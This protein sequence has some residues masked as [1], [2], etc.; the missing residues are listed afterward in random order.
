M[1]RALLMNGLGFRFQARGNSMYPT[2]RDGEIL[3]VQPTS[4]RELRPGDI[5][6]FNDGQHF[7]AHRLVRVDEDMFVTR[8]D[9]ALDADDAIH[10]SQ[11]IGKVIAKENSSGAR[12]RL[13]SLC[14]VAAKLR[15]H[16]TRTRGTV[17]RR[18]QR[19]RLRQPM[20]SLRRV[21]SRPSCAFR[22]AC[23]L[24]FVMLLAAFTVHAQVAVDASTST[25]ARVTGTPTVN[26][27]HNT[28]GAN[29][30][31]IVGVSLNLTNSATA[32]VT[33]I[34]YN[35][36]ALTR[37]GAH[38]DAG[39]TRRVEMWSLLAPVTGN[40][41]VA[42][43]LSIPGGG[44]IGMVAGA[45]TFT[46]VDQTSP[47]APF[48]SADGA[49]GTFSSLDVP[50]MVNGFVIDTL[51]IG[52][53]LTVA[54]GASQTS[55]WNKSS[56]VNGVTDVR[57]T[58]STRPGAPSVPISETFGGTSNWSLGALALRPFQS[59]LAVTATGSSAFF[60]QNLTYT[61]KITNNG[62]STATGATLTDTLAAGLTLVSATPS[63]G[64]CAGTPTITCNLGTIAPAAMATVTIVVTPGAT[65]GY[66][67]T[68]TITSTTPD[69]VGGNNSATSVAFS[70]SNACSTP[71]QN[72]AGGTLAGIVNTYYPAT[73]NAAAGSKTITLGIATGSTTPIAIGD[74]LLVMQI[75]DAAINSTNTI[76][77]GD[78]FTGSGFTNPNSSGLY[79]FVTA[80][81]AVPLTGGTL[82]LTATGPGGGLIYS[83]T[84][85]A[86]TGAQGQRK[87]QVVR[88]PQ[89]STATLGSTLTAAAWN[90]STGGILALDVAG[91][92]TLGSATVSVNG[93]GFRGGAGMQLNGGTGTNTDFR[94]TAPAAY[95]GV[96]TP[97]ADGPK[98]EGIGGTPHWVESGVTFLNTGAEG[99]PNGSMARG[100]PGNAG[101]GGTDGDPNTASPNGNDQNAGGGGGAN[102]GAGGSGGDSWNS[103]LSS[104]GLAGAAFP[105][106]ITR[107]VLGGGGG[108]GSRNNSD[109]DLQAASGAAGGGIVI[110]RAGSLSGTATITAN[111]TAAYNGTAN[112]AAGAGGAGGSII[113]TSAQGGES[114]LTLSAHGGR[115]GDA[116]NTMAFSLGERHGPGGGGGGGVALISGP[117]ASIDVSGGGSGLTL[118][119]G[120]PYGA[121][122]GAAGTS[123]TNVPPLSLPGDQ[124][125]G[126]CVSDL[127]IAKS[128]TGNFTRGTSGTYTVTVSNI[129]LNMLTSGLVTVSDTLPIGLTPTAASGTGWSCS[130]SAQTLTCT[131]SDALAAGG[132]YPAISITVSVAQSAPNQVTNTAT[133]SGG[134][135]VNTNNDSAS[136]VTN[137]VSSAD[138]AITKAGSPNPVMQGQTLTYTLTVTNNGPSD[139]TGVSVSDTLPTQVSFVSATPS[140][141]TCSQASGTVTCALGTL[142][143][144]SSATITI[145][146]TAVT[147]SS[148]TN[149]ATVS[150]NEADP[151]SAN[152]T[153]SQ[154]EIITFP[155]RVSLV[156][157]TAQAGNGQTLLSWKTGSE[158]RNLGFNVYGDENGQ[159]V[160]LNPSLIAGSALTFRASLQQHTA[161]SYGWIDR[162]PSASGTYWLEDVDLDG[163]RTLHGPVSAQAAAAA[164]ANL[165]ASPTIAEVNKVPAVQ[166]SSEMSH[167]VEAVL[168]D[169]GDRKEL[170]EVQ[171][172]LAASPAVKIQVDHEGWYRVTQ[173][174]LVAAGLKASADA[175]YLQLYSQAIEQPIRITGATDGSGGFGPDA[176][177]EF[178]GTGVDTAY[179]SD[180]VYWLVV[181]NQPGKRIQDAS[182]SGDG[183]HQPQSFSYTVGL[184]QRT[185]YFAALLKPGDNFFGALVSTTPVDQ[186]LTLADIATAT[187]QNATVQIV[188]Q[189]VTDGTHDVNVS[190]NGSNL[191]DLTFGNQDEG[192]QSW[193]VPVNQL[194]A[195]PNTITL[196]AQNGA[197]DV[198]LVNYIRIRYQH[199]YTAE[200]DSLKFTAQAGDH[201]VVNGFQ[202]TPT[203]LVD[204]TDPYQPV[205]L[206][207]Q[208]ESVQGGYV[209]DAK[210]PWS[211]PGSHTLL[212][213]ADVQL[214][215]PAAMLANKPSHWHAAQAGADAVMI[216]YADFIGQ[217][218]PL[219]QL[220]KNQGKSV[221]V[222]DVEDL[223][224]E[225]AFGE[226]N[227][228]ALKEFLRAALAQWQKKPH[229]L[230]LVGDAS[231][232]PHNYLGFGFFDFVPTQIIP[233]SLLKTASDDW[234]SDFNDTGTAQIPTGRL[235]V[236]TQ[237]DATTV[238][239]KIV[240]YEKQQGGAWAE[241][242]LVVADVDDP[243]LSFTL[244]AE[245]VQALLPPSMMATDVFATNLD[246]NT[247]R[248]QILDGINS[249]KLLVNYNGHGSIEIWSGEDL[250]DNT[251]AG[252]L[253]NGSSLPVFVI[254]NCLNGFFHD[255][256][257]ESLAEALLLSK[258]GGAVAVWASSAL[259]AP[260]P[261]LQMDQSLMQSVFG[262]SP[263]AL[264]DAIAAAKSSIDDTEVRRTFILFG[265]P[266]LRLKS[267]TGNTITPQH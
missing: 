3:H 152:N 141:G 240:N 40:H 215:T 2:I 256:Y 59:D 166:S 150:A 147:P 132:S 179:S 186:T 138:V 31:L 26:F 198:S 163:T 167:A 156:T 260:Q 180:R 120:V 75:Q 136:D 50:S 154:T 214:G 22:A 204:I 212:A 100:A 254:M 128:H 140:Q 85:A 165:A 76:A 193:Q 14:G 158:A 155:T 210:I 64:T 74:L 202:T 226:R 122:A 58:G 255:V 41:S 178:Y 253:T 71:S 151:N 232:D 116:W 127:T 67:N 195:G 157:F 45:T 37:A 38:N 87:F 135:E 183:G 164:V 196:T 239:G 236:R 6:L 189:G 233:T 90:G 213:L 94:L 66:A 247:A 25:N 119:P 206:T 79:E 244:E 134:G 47:L 143:S 81:S 133:V 9:S 208:A 248:Q 35:G 173:P 52:G 205:N 91:T 160:R 175:R 194:Q 27:N 39:N 171:F 192:N 51:A 137:I 114:G 84:N 29:R 53:D 238:V 55:Q 169:R 129:S 230:L 8:G 108:A 21:L 103:N 188:L 89:Y 207:F 242:A 258:N 245:S 235:P 70:Q 121:T 101:G 105:A 69:L 65:G 267:G 56:G 24:L 131:R 259:T 168:P 7:R 130:I 83:Y 82:T 112:D 16:L 42:V 264:G 159:R 77:Y 123:A 182:G 60:P 10:A 172:R 78:G 144:G 243:T 229:Y 181:G 221:A 23:L 97:G 184:K 251:S 199:T 176:A 220:R 104:G 223:Y 106:S 20:K 222:V 241:Q 227:P 111:G 118:N 113:L 203:Y 187:T 86:A 139:A 95:I 115:G 5:V 161:R 125:G 170:R 231:L 211:N 49:A 148:V 162:S 15:F 72:G 13:I 237:D 88:V 61:I 28:A 46:G 34:T 146:V 228:A 153:A 177:I 96:S 252:T 18:T 109:G 11:I 62:P 257:T 225:F 246:A 190:L 43:T 218:N 19:W 63:Q 191:G 98:G 99:Y 32:A 57:G 17:S 145:K 54:I 102:G 261:Q 209:L 224:D 110:I 73:A 124:S 263:V 44:T 48:V 126:V 80:A 149:T 234:F 107:V 197:T 262:P 265:D 68:A 93:L 1:T 174:Q 216:S 36:V 30:I 33:G 250:L 92:L 217:L 201:I 12:L 219:V 117:G 142:T 200:S 185:T 249:G 266:L 4:T